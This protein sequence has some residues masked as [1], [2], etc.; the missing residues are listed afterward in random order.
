MPKLEISY[1][2]FVIEF[3]I[4]IRPCSS[5]CTDHIP[6]MAEGTEV[7][8]ISFAN[9]DIF[10]AHPHC[11]PIWVAFLYFEME[12]FVVASFLKIWLHYSKLVS[13]SILGFYVEVCD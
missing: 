12:G 2:N 10:M 4:V 3:R 7:E 6:T 1:F 11:Y 9:Y 13:T 5:I 8:G